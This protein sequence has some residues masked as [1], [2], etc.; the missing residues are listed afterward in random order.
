MNLN[1]KLEKLGISSWRGKEF[2][3]LGET[4]I[5]RIEKELRSNFPED[6]RQFLTTY[7]E[8]DFEEYVE[9]SNGNGAIYFQNHSIGWDESGEI[10]NPKLASCFRFADN[11]SS[12]ICGLE[13]Q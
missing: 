7:G 1:E 6:Y 4:E 12:F 10:E 8:S 5:K 2:N 3:P 9:Y 13:I 11:F